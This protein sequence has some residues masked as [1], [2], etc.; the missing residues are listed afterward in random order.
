ML[1][2]IL[3]RHGIILPPDRL[4]LLEGYL[5]SLRRYNR[6]MDLTNVPE[7]D[8]AERHIADSLKPLAL[9]DVPLRGR[10]ADVGTGAGFPGLPIAIAHPELSLTL[11]DAQ[12][13]RCDF[14]KETIG[15]LQIGNCEVICGR[16]EDLGRSP[17]ARGKFDAA[18][19]RAVAGTNVLA[20]YLLPLLKTGGAALCWKG[21]KGE[22]EVP[23]GDAAAALMGGSPWQVIY[24]PGFPEKGC[25]SS[26]SRRGRLRIS[27]PAATACPP[28]GRSHPAERN[29]NE[30]DDRKR[31][32]ISGGGRA[33]AAP[34]LSGRSCQ[35]SRIHT[36]M[37]PFSRLL[38][39]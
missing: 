23:D 18:V 1:K 2:T 6:V 28:K 19:T 24:V 30:P 13:K 16:A 25:C 37:S 7:A 31:C 22:E 8:W 39:A 11:L 14:L 15:A 29:E 33:W 3:E 21:P 4:A 17:S 36:V 34:E 38:Q 26:A 10:W 9:A 20:E 35:A 32:M 27:T 5:D 12:K